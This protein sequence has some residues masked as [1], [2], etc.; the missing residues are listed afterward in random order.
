MP[1]CW[2]AGAEPGFK[3]CDSRLFSPMFLICRI[4]E[5]RSAPAHRSCDLEYGD[6]PKGRLSRNTKPR[7]NGLK[8][9]VVPRC[10]GALRQHAQNLSPR[11][12]TLDCHGFVGPLKVGWQQPKR[13]PLHFRSAVRPLG[14]GK[15]ADL[16]N[17]S[18]FASFLSR[19]QGR[20]LTSCPGPGILQHSLFIIDKINS[21]YILACEA[22][23]RWR[24]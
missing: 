16:H 15:A 10:I 13:G 12:A 2:R 1:L 23:R 17:R 5:L 20:M 8:K 3:L 18:R 11:G 9:P 4:A 19:W 24:G 14:Q 6:E 7:G 21:R 22:S